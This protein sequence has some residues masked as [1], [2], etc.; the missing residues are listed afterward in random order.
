[1]LATLVFLIE[2]AEY[3]V[4]M[5]ACFAFTNFLH[6]ATPEQIKCVSSACRRVRADG[7][8]DHPL[9]RRWECAAR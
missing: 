3:D 6:G 1:M 2:Y 5:E 9:G 7:H 4:V 8:T